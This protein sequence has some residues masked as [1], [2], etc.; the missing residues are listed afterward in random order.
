MRQDRA[1]LRLAPPGPFSRLLTGAGIAVSFSLL[2]GCSSAGVGLS[3]SSNIKHRT[4]AVPSPYSFPLTSQA[5]AAQPSASAAASRSAAAA[6][7]CAAFADNTFVYVRTVTTAPNK[8][9]T[10]SANPVTVVCGGPDDLHY[11]TA[12]ATVTG[13]VA[14]WAAI[15]I[16]DLSTMR[17]EPIAASRLAAY[18]ATDRGSRIFMI[19]GVLTGID[20]MVEQY[21]P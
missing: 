2:A 13:Y 1:W 19:T 11:D 5:P 14:P 15:K 12:S 17:S 9:L 18:L 3:G 8:S 4:A 20:A 21:H 16:F 10:L 7:A 6:R